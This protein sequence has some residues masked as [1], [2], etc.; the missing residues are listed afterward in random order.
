MRGR[1]QAEQ[2]LRPA[3]QRLITHCLKAE[4]DVQKAEADKETSS[5][6]LEISRQENRI[7]QKEKCA[8]PQDRP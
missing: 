1:R 5:A 2:I 6:V 3:F 4:V 7:D 8:G